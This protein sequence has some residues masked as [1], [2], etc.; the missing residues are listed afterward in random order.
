MTGDP[1]RELAL[2]ADIVAK[3]ANGRKIVIWGD[4]VICHKMI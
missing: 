3:N 1:N 4:C 2:I